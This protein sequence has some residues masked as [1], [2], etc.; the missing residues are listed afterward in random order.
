[1]KRLAT[2]GLL[3]VMA[4]VTATG[5]GSSDVAVEIDPEQAQQMNDQRQMIEQME[6]QQGEALRQMREQQLQERGQQP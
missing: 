3:A 2:L 5:C 6:A 1:M 4:M